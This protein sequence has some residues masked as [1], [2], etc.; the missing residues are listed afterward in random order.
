[1]DYPLLNNLYEEVEGSS[2][3]FEVFEKTNNSLNAR[4]IE[5][6]VE[7]GFVIGP[8]GG[9]ERVVSISFNYIEFF[10]WPLDNGKI[11]LVLKNP[12]RSIRTFLQELHAVFGFGFSVSEAEL[13]VLNFLYALEDLSDVESVKVSKARVGGIKLSSKASANVEV[14]SSENALKNVE[15]FV[16]TDNFTIDKL[17]FELYF[18]GIK[19][20]AEVSRTGIVSA[21]EAFFEYM[22]EELKDLIFKCC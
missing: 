10:A 22:G 6:K 16:G 11:Y 7:E 12:S 14:S 20:K 8:Y 19:F 13:S 18:K 17:K 2:K 9:E 5:K 1:M 3:G 15:D 21:P 4:F